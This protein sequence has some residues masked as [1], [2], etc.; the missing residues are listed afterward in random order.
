MRTDFLVQ[1]V[2]QDSSPHALIKNTKYALVMCV[3]RL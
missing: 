3:R 2:V 1:E